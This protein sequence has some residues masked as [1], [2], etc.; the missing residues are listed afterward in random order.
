M[1][2]SNNIQFNGQLCIPVKSFTSDDIYYIN[3]LLDKDLNKIKY[4]CNCGNKYSVGSRS[5]CKHISH[6]KLSCFDN[7][8]IGIKTFS[9]EIDKYFIPINSIESCNIYCVTITINKDKK[10]V[11]Y[12]C[13]CGSF[14]GKFRNKCKHISY[15]YINSLKNLETVNNTEEELLEDFCKISI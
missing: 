5:K 9:K 10:D 13:T 15:V 12:E 4:N 6:I 3:V 14:Y 8:N 2:F 1:N 11:N 7:I